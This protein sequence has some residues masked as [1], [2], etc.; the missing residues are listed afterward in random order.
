MKIKGRGTKRIKEEVQKM[1]KKFKWLAI[2]LVIVAV[3]AIGV[4]VMV[5]SAATPTSTP[6]TQTCNGAGSG[7]RFGGVV[8]DEVVTKLLGMTEDE[9]H[10]LRQQGK[11]LVQIAATKNVTEKQLVDAIMA[12]KKT[13]VQ[14]RVTAK[15]LTQEQANLMIQRMEQQTTQAVNRSSVGPMGEQGMG[16]GQCGNGTGNGTCTGQGKMNR[17]AR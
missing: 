8:I 14:A 12:Y 13:Q 6:N 5:A 10:A 15:T 7:F 17:R 11:S 16:N 1:G 9:I 3:L 4:G 2:T